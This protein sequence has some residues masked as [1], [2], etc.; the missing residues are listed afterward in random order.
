MRGKINSPNGRLILALCCYVALIA[1][2]LVALLPVR[3]SHERFVLAFVIA[4]FAILI[5][6]TIRFRDKQL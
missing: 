2:A 6:K 1:L 4:F 3:T 5:V